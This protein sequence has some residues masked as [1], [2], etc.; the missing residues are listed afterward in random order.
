[1]RLP[2]IPPAAI[3][4]EGLT[5]RYRHVTAVDDLSFTVRR[6][7][8]TGFLGPNGAGKTT[9]LKAI[10]GIGRPTAGRA[11]IDG[12]P[13]AS[14]A[15]DASKLG[16]YIDA[17]PGRSA[18]VGRVCGAEYCLPVPVVGRHVPKPTPIGYAGDVPGSPDD[19]TPSPAMCLTSRRRQH[20]RTR[21]PCGATA[22]HGRQ[23]RR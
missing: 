23:R 10:V 1:M 17:H 13:A 12:A 20:L 11:L 6:G 14:A 15:P 8:V 5:K 19:G 22:A 16:V 7:A 2:E 4:V 21:T 18:S 3:V 9:A